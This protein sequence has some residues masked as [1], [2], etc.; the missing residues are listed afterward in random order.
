[1]LVF[2]CD[3]TTIYSAGANVRL[4]IWPDLELCGSIGMPSVGLSLFAKALNC[5]CF[6]RHWFESRV[7]SA[8]DRCCGRLRGRRQER[9]RPRCCLSDS[10]DTISQGTK[11]SLTAA[12]AVISSRPTPDPDSW[13]DPASAAARQAV[14]GQGGPAPSGVV[15]QN[16]RPLL[17]VRADD[18]G[19]RCTELPLPEIGPSSRPRS[20]RARRRGQC[21]AP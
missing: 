10:S 18:L 4:N 1:M 6:G 9:I 19:R 5:Q 11:F 17:F 2:F 7:S 16:L 15:L 8:T 3:F 21:V 13:G 12:S 20:R 14:S